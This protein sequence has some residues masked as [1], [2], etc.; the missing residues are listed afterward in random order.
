MPNSSPTSRRLLTAIRLATAAALLTATAA[1]GACNVSITNQAEGRAEWKRDYT[2]TADGALEIRNTNGQIDIE[3]SDGD[4]VTVVAERIAKA[5]TEEAA[6]K[7]AEEMEIKETVSSSSILLDGRT[8]SSGIMIG[9]SRQI[10]FHIR[11]P[12]GARLT[13]TTTNGKLVIRDMTGELRLDTTNGEIEGRNLAGTTRAETT[14][15]VISLDYAA[16]GSGGVTAETTNGKVDISLAKSLKARISARVVNGA[17]DTEDLTL[18]TSEKSRRR[19]SGTLN[20]GGPEIRVE[21]T[22]GAVSFRGRQ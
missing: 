12:K 16:L 19:L 3:P 22:N 2:L 13:L 5:A 11:A 14:N 15:G 10:K 6:K 21:T 4:K 8:N 17:I 1:L 7:A 18:E 20:G 9:G